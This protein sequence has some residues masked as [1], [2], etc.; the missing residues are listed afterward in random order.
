MNEHPLTNKL[1]YRH[2]RIQAGVR[3]L[4][5][6][7]HLPAQ[8]TKILTPCIDHVDTVIH[9]GPPIGTLQTDNAAHECGFAGARLSNQAGDFAFGDG[10]GHIV[11]RLDL[12]LADRAKRLAHTLDL[13]QGSHASP[14]SVG[15]RWHAAEPPPETLAGAGIS[16]EQTSSARGHRG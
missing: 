16:R 10:Y 5:N 9:D 11:Q 4:K 7:L 1:L 14:C 2:A 12:W 13:Q 6:H 15:V 8:T 3:I